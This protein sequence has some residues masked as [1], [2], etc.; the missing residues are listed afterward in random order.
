MPN[1][2]LIFVWSDR[3]LLSSKK[4]ETKI[5]SKIR[6]KFDCQKGPKSYRMHS[7][8]DQIRTR[9]WQLDTCH[10]DQRAAHFY[11]VYSWALAFLDQKSSWRFLAGYI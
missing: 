1:F 4:F 2:W 11:C 3:Q 7:L 10:N 9:R 5:R 8:L 6:Q